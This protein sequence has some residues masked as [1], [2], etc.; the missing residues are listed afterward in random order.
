MIPPRLRIGTRGSRL[1]LAQT[2]LVRQA[3]ACAHS[4]LAAPG[5]LEVVTIRTTGDLLTDRPLAE[6]GGKGL[7]CKE[8]EAAL[9]A[10]RIDCAVHSIK[11]LPTWLP[12]GLVV[13]AVLER[14][15][16]RDVLIGRP[17]AVI[18]ELP[19]A[20]LI[21][22]SSVRRKAQLLARRAD[23]RVVDF[24]GNVDTRLRTLAAGDVDAT[25]LA[26]AGLRRLGIEDA[27][28]VVLTPDEMLPA[29]GQGAI[30]IEC[31]AD[32]AA[33]LALLAAIDHPASAVC[34]RAERALL[35]ALDGSCHTPIAGHAEIVAAGRLHLRAL[36]ARPDGS[37]CLRTERAGLPG[38]AERLGEDAGA[39]LRARAGPA[40]FD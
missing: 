40:F 36:V 31:R 6:L 14:A 20:A 28:M 12:G 29:V 26:L 5:A 24:R 39:E 38:D 32:D 13:G 15:D 25:L 21:G 10:R 35:A 3:L 1:A 16:P 2:E 22:T 4:E 37:E 18:A 33:T 27:G 17:P 11:D 8:I 34:V 7:F 9:L 23:L 19:Q 30:G